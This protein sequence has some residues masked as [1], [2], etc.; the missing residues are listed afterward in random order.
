[1]FGDL[2]IA[3]K[4]VALE[5]EFH[6][7]NVMYCNGH[8]AS[9]TRTW[10]GATLAELVASQAQDIAAHTA[11]MV[12]DRAAARARVQGQRTSSIKTCT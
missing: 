8:S 2:V 10:E 9:G 5:H 1:M 4:E 7:S 12:E 3:I 11:Q 6:Q